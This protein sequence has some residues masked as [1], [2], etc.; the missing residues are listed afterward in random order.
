MTPAKLICRAVLLAWAVAGV[1]RGQNSNDTAVQNAVYRDSIAQDQLHVQADRLRQDLVQLLEDYRQNHAPPTDIAQLQQVIDRLGSLSDRDMSGVVQT[2]RDVGKLNNGPTVQNRLVAASQE[3]LAIQTSLKKLT[4]QLTLRQTQQS[5]EQRL[6]QLVLRQVTNLHHTRDIAAAGQPQNLLPHGL[7]VIGELAVAEQS[8]IVNELTLLTDA[9]EKAAAKTAENPDGAVFAETLKLSSDLRLDQQAATAA[10]ETSS[11]DFAK[12]AAAQ[13]PLLISLQAL[14][15]KMESAQSVA[16]RL[17]DLAAR[18]KD[19]AAQQ[20]VLAE[21]TQAAKNTAADEIRDQ[22]DKLAEQV[23]ALRAELGALDIRAAAQLD[24][25]EQ[26]MQSIDGLLRKPDALEERHGNGADQAG[27]KAQVASAQVEAGRQ[28]EAIGATLDQ[29]AG[30]VAQATTPETAGQA[31]ATLQHLGQELNQALAQ[32]QALAAQPGAAAAAAQEQQV[33]AEVANMQREALPLDTG[34]AGTLGQAAAQMQQAQDPQTPNSAGQAA[35]SLAQAQAQV[36]RE[37]QEAAKAAAVQQ[38]ADGLA[39]LLRDVKA[40]VQ[41][42]GQVMEQPSLNDLT[43]AIQQMAAAQGVIAQA[44][45]FVARDAG[46][47]PPEVKG[48]LNVAQTDLTTSKM[49]AAQ[50]QKKNALTANAHAQTELDDAIKLLSQSSAQMLAQALPESV[51]A[52]DA[53]QT[54]PNA[55]QGRGGPPLLAQQNAQPQNG[56]QP[57]GQRQPGG[58]QQPGGQ[59]QQGGQGA[60]GPK[61][62]PAP[63]GR[64]IGGQGTDDSSSDHYLASEGAASGYTMVNQGGG[65]SIRQA[66]TLFQKE[67]VPPEYSDMVQQYSKNLAEG[68]VPAK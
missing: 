37:A 5:M 40:Q 33:A 31:A 4:D 11:R 49:Q 59:Q 67:K 14:A 30:N 13:E 28:L 18:I 35:A 61:G 3:Q 43:P 1:C 44:L 60:P 32:Q 8:A 57:G 51:M 39:A 68:E 21:S 46:I 27:G 45:T 66:V 24:P 53:Q 25:A 38:A 55:D 42:A 2:L 7:K 65:A 10:A 16:E 23:A 50:V 63:G 56:A 17:R 48:D 12:A 19:V 41:Q 62:P 36:Q 54:S 26:A 22:Q 64:A 20:Q 9:L 47:L 52:Q 15:E 58:R 34:L 6:R 29:E